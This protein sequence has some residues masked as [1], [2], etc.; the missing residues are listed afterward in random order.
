MSAVKEL[1]R[2]EADGSVS[3]GDYE[4][5]E[6]TK[7]SDF[8]HEGDIYKVKT[9]SGITRLEKNEMFVYESE[10]GTAVFGLKETEEGISFR[11][12]GPADAQIIAQGAAETDYD[13]FIDGEKRDTERSNLGGKIS[14]SVELDLDREV[15]VTLLRRS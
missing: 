1:I 3:F 10:P 8:E 15:E 13:I 12:S 14:F 7:K 5:G 6:K 4:L 9:F 2:A 11:V